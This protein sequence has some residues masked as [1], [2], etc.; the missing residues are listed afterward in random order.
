MKPSP[1][2]AILLVTGIALLARAAVLA[3]RP[4]DW[5]HTDSLAYLQQA[6]AIRAGGW[7]A[8]FP[9]GYPLLLSLVPGWPG[10]PG[11]LF[12]AAVLHIV[13]GAATAPL[14]FALAL[15]L[16][17][18]LVAA[19]IAGLAMA[20]FPEHVHTSPLLM[21]DVPTGVL[22]ILAAW[23]GISRRPLAAGLAL[24][25]A[26]TFRSTV[27]P[28]ALLAPFLL[29][30]AGERRGAGRLLAGFALPVAIVLILGWTR[31]GAWTLGE[32][33][34]MN[35]LQG[36]LSLGWNI[37][38]PNL[39]DV[40]MPTGK[41][42]GIYFQGL[43]DNPLFFLRQR[44]AALSEIW[45]VLPGDPSA[46]SLPV[47]LLMSLRAPVLVLA[48]LGAWRAR[49][50]RAVLWCAAAVAW[51]TLLHACLYGYP[52]YALQALP[53]AL[54]LASAAPRGPGPTRGIAFASRPESA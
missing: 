3:W 35:I 31:T 50:N 11:H 20:L 13:V 26:A 2:L 14:V 47:R 7:A 33:L 48:L 43:L 54:A 40:H 5:V 30:P 51:V 27:V 4:G 9:N 38:L 24:G 41:A 44:L 49:G 39:A 37:R 10:D 19:W 34:P 22:L 23:A 1:R 15:R 45:G 29:L 32:N 36:H 46:R 18:S 52:R 17:G 16:T 21:T 12:L 28:L 8:F 53:L 25:A 42:L 6:Q